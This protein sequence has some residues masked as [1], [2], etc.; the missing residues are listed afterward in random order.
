MP[1]YFG[2]EP[3]A[4]L[5]AGRERRVKGHP[6]KPGEPGE[7]SGGFV[8][9]GP[10]RKAVLRL[11]CLNSG[12]KC[13][14]FGF[15]ECGREKNFMTRGIGVHTAESG[16]IRL[17]PETDPQALRD[18]GQG[19]MRWRRVHALSASSSPGAYFP[20]SESMSMRMM[21][22]RTIMESGAGRGHKDL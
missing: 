4:D 11:M 8:F 16:A 9:H 10:E 6:R 7:I 21:A 13:V 15:G 22:T 3:P 20:M 17:C 14:A 2:Q 18:E 5:H 1:R 12:Q 19:L